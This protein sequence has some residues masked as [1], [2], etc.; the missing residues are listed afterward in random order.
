M[1][2][3]FTVKIAQPKSRGVLPPAK[4]IMA[5]RRVKRLKTRNTK[6]RFALN[7]WS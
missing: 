7:D 6:D 2:S 3:G 1:K 5:D 4:R